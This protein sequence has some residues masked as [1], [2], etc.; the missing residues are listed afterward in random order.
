ME[1]L[2]SRHISMDEV[3]DSVAAAFSEIFEPVRA[4]TR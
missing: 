3:C 2:L 4:D 1:R